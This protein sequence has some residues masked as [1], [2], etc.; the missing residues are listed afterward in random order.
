MDYQSLTVIIINPDADKIL[1]MPTSRDFEYN[2]IRLTPT[3]STYYRF[4]KNI[5]NAIPDELKFKNC[6]CWTS[7]IK[8]SIVCY[9]S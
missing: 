9:R 6:S 3:E 2:V 1:I 4:V 5:I 8:R 7:I